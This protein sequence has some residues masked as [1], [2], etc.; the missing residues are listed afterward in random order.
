MEERRT[1]DRPPDTLPVMAVSHY[2]DVPV[3]EEGLA[4]ELE[5]PDPTEAEREDDAESLVVE[6]GGDPDFIDVNEPIDVAVLREISLRLDRPVPY[7]AGPPA[8]DEGIP[9]FYCDQMLNGM[10]QYAGHLAGKKHRKNVRRAEELGLRIEQPRLIVQR[11]QGMI[12]SAPSRPVGNP[13]PYPPPVVTEPVAEA[14]AS[15]DTAPLCRLVHPPRRGP[16]T[17]PP[18]HGGPGS[19]RRDRSEGTQRTRQRTGYHRFKHL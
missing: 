3:L 17:S 19:S 16:A 10:Y 8:E 18:T 5:Q 12:R 2:A 9:C 15:E 4:S 1:A 13:P 14:R 11:L 6:V 7:A